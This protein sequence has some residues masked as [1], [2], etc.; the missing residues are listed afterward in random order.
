MT[1]QQ[2]NALKEFEFIRGMAELKALL[3]LSLQ[4]P[5]T[6]EQYKRVIELKPLMFKELKGGLNRKCKSRCN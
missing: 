6:N 2:E 4:H 5:L 3:K 1:I